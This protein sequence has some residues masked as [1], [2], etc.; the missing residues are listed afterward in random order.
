MFEKVSQTRGKEE[1]MGGVKESKWNQR[2][3]SSAVSL[4]STLGTVVALSGQVDA[5]EIKK[6][7]GLEE[8]QVKIGNVSA[9][10]PKLGPA[11]VTPPNEPIIIAQNLFPGELANLF[12]AQV[13][14]PIEGALYYFNG[15]SWVLA[16]RD[17]GGR[18]TPQMARIDNRDRTIAGIS[19]DLYIYKNTT[20]GI[21]L[22]MP[23]RNK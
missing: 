16:S 19:W 8:T 22:C 15:S 12:E 3:I 2:L 5:A 10:L 23:F 18:L 9:T 14:S 4:V 20:N 7:G 6:V 17:W 21:V 13:K 1:S 11:E